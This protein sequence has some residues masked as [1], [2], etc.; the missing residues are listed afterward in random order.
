M[1]IH[2]LCLL[3][4]QNYFDRY[5]GSGLRAWLDDAISSMRCCL[6]LRQPVI[7]SLTVLKQKLNIM[8]IDQC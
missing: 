3:G 1:D 5:I 7:L 2:E 6:H 4:K 8:L